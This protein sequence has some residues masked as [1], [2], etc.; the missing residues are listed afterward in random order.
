M[1]PILVGLLFWWLPDIARTFCRNKCDVP[2]EPPTKNIVND[3][4]SKQEVERLIIA[5]VIMGIQKI[6]AN[7]PTAKKTLK[8]ITDILK[9]VNAK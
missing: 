6:I 7:H 4:V 8:N 2:P 1:L 5:A 3:I 9:K